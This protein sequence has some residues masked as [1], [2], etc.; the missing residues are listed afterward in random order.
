V[1]KNPLKHKRPRLGGEEALLQL[2]LAREVA[3]YFR[4]AANAAGEIIERFRRV[5][6]QWRTIAKKLRIPA[7]EQERMAESFR[8]AG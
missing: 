8:L 3:P 4:V 5:V 2:D 7:R 6:S 1:G